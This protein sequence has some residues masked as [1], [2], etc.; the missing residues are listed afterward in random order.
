MVFMVLRPN[1][2]VDTAA[3]FADP[4]NILKIRVNSPYLKMPGPALHS[5]GLPDKPYYTTRDVCKVLGIS[6]D[7]FRQRIYRATTP[8]TE[9]LAPNGS[10][11]WSKLLS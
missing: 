7:T 3:Q 11:P 4:L 6:P 9:R 1:E 5:L 8:N 2:H 10:L